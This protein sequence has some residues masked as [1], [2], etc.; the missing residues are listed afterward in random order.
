M[1]ASDPLPRALLDANILW[2][3]VLRDTL[4]RTAERPHYQPLWSQEILEEMVRT[5]LAKRV[6]TRQ[7]NL[8][9]TVANMQRAFPDATVSGYTPLTLQLTNHPGD[10]HVLAAAIHGRAEYIITWNRRHFL[11]SATEIHGIA[12]LTPDTFLCQLWTRHSESIREILVQQGAELRSPRSATT[13][14]ES[15]RRS[16]V[17]QFVRLVSESLS[18]N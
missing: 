2:S 16:A 11:P 7:E 15:L 18:A 17:T 3:P 8:A 6:D 1:T 9:R 5:I 13:V 12:V 14:L 4:L 10:R